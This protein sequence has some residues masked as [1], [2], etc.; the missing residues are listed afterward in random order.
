MSSIQHRRNDR[1]DSWVVRFRDPGGTH[2]GKAF[3][4]LGSAERWQ[5]FFDARGEREADRLAQATAVQRNTPGAHTI[6]SWVAA[7]IEAKSGIHEGTRRDY[8]GYLARNIAPALGDVPVAALTKQDVGQWVN[9][10]AASGLSPKTIKN[11]HSLLSDAL[12]AA[13]EDGQ[14]PR[15][16]AKSVKLPTIAPASA[17]ERAPT[18]LEVDAIIAAVQAPYPAVV[19]LLAR[20]GMRWG[21]A[22]ALQ[23]G[24]VDLDRATITV[25]R[26]WKHTGGAKAPELGYPKTKRGHRTITIDDGLADL[27]EPLCAGR[28]RGAWLFT[29]VRGRPLRHDV[30]YRQVWRKAVDRLHAEGVIGHRYRIHDL[31]HHHAAAMIDA[32]YPLT[33]LQHR[34]GHESVTSTSDRYGSRLLNAHAA[35]LGVL[36]EVCRPVVKAGPRAIEYHEG[37][38]NTQPM[39]ES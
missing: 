6:G 27:L 2:R 13:V 4:D 21:E 8:R 38:H 15:N 19:T 9:Q 25:A 23:V 24:D 12:A 18:R 1:S 32:G 16:V 10:L 17:V 31:R 33:H 26:A 37:P 30:F 28:E 11:R 20:T 22:T 3:V 36:A 7:H 29:T 5:A 34:L 39:E 35:T 14:V